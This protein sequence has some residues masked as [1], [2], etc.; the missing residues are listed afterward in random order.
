M[1][2][3]TMRTAA[4]L[5]GELGRQVRALRLQLDRT[6][7]D[8]AAEANVSVS[9]LQALEQGAGSSLRTLTQ[10]ARALGQTE[11]L[12]S[13]APAVS[14]SPMQLLRE[15]RRAEAAAPKRARGSR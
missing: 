8:V 14:V 9:A 6:Q 11:W 13:F 3:G 5:E 15:R 4:E 12:T 2:P 10:V 7:A 1:A